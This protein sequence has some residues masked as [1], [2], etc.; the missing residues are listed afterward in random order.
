[1]SNPERSSYLF[2]LAKEAGIPLQRGVEAEF[3]DDAYLQFCTSYRKWIE[4]R[5]AALRKY[6]S[7]TSA[8]F[9][10]YLPYNSR[11]FQLAYQTVWY[12]DEIVVRD[13]VVSVIGGQPSEREDHESSKQ[14]LRQIVQLLHCFAQAIDSGY[15]LLAGPTLIPSLASVHPPEIG[16]LLEVDTVREELDRAVAFGLRKVQGEG[17]RTHVVYQMRLESGE[18]VGAVIES[19]KKGD[20]I[21][22]VQVGHPLPHSTADEIMRL[23]GKDVRKQARELYPREVH[24]TLHNVAVSGPLNATTLF[25]RSVDSAII[26]SLRDLQSNP[27]VR[28]SPVD[29]L[30]LALPYVNGVPPDRLLDLRNELP[31]AFREF[32]ARLVSI[33]RQTANADSTDALEMAR[34]QVEL[35]LLPAMRGLE[36]EMRAAAKKA[37]IMG[38]GLPAVA[39]VATLVGA[40]VGASFNPIILAATGAGVIKVVADLAGAREKASGSPFY[41]VWRAKQVADGR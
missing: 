41:F 9:R 34:E 39:A 10:C 31:E 38:Y 26:A 36:A 33:V 7:E 1:M 14:G 11:V 2:D 23:T 29:T 19:P 37:K 16:R 6:L 32:R 8:K 22:L 5:D 35:L 18:H 13:P 20:E 27:A 30:N 3:T 4:S 28:L 12:L 25:D 21:P 17:G 15:M 24:R 40:T